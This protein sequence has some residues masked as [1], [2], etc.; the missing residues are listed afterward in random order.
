[1]RLGCF[2]V[3][4]AVVMV[5]GGGQ[6]LYMG[7][8]HRECRV[9]SYDEFVKE[10]PRHGWFQVNGCR[11][12]LVEAMYRS[13]LIGGVKEAYIPVRG[14][15]GEDSPTHLLVLTKDPEILG[16]INDLR[17]LDKGDEAAALKALAANRDRLVSTRDVKGMLQYGIDVK[18]RVGDRLSRLDSSLAP[19]YVILEEGKAPELGFSLFIF[20]GGL[21]LSGYLAYRLFSRP[22]GPS[23]AADEPA[24]LTD[25]GNDAEP[26][27]LPRSGARRPG[28]G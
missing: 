10:K 24:M 17:K 25:W 9:L 19:D 2:V 12:N 14:T 7:L 8:V 3:L 28:A 21:A 27:P 23:P 22:S 4:I 20:L 18:S 16:T 1:M 5:I 13:K 26:P 15:S 11:L 6:G